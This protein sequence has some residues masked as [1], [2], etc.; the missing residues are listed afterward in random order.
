MLEKKIY[1]FQ[2]DLQCAPYG[3]ICS[4]STDSY[5]Y[6]V[7]ILYMYYNMMKFFIIIDTK[8]NL[9]ETRLLVAQ[10]HIS[11]ISF[12]YASRRT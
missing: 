12:V 3:P 5:F 2:K 11:Y 1:D 9:I 10:R 4:F 7:I 8:K 6:Y